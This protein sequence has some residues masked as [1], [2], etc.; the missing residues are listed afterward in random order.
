MQK[1]DLVYLTEDA[2]HDAI[3]ELINAEA[4]GPGR[5]TRAAAR[6][7]EQGPHDR[8]LSFVCADKGETIASVRMTPVL[9]GTVKGHMLGPLAVRPS[10]KC[11]GIG[12]ELVRIAIEAAR[13]NGSEAVIL[14]GDPPYYMPLGFEKI[15]YNAL[16]FP[17]PVDPGRVLVVPL[18]EDVHARLKGVIGWRDSQVVVPLDTVEGVED[19]EPLRLAANG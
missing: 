12:R 2:S 15:A 3:I 11:L 18:A 1:H 16:S 9:A 13:R 14:I 17:G 7:R 4:F 8:T 10:H 19:C 5:F 6:I